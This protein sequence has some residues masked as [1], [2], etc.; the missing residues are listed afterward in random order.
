MQE[1]I[2]PKDT[3]SQGETPRDVNHTL[4][5]DPATVEKINALK[6]SLTPPTYTPE[7]SAQEKDR[8]LGLLKD[9]RYD[10]AVR[11]LAQATIRNKYVP[12]EL[13]MF[14]AQASHQDG[15]SMRDAFRN[16]PRMTLEDRE[17][18]MIALVGGKSV[19]REFAR[20][21]LLPT[22]VVDFPT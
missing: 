8:I 2:R 5:K 12:K 19:L 16:E 4:H 13:V 17:A 22:T 10:D 18:L 6:E 11:N 3:P 15:Y 21:L 7:E 1:F 14:M 20:I 9:L